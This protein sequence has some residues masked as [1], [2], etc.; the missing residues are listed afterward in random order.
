MK[1]Y[2]VLALLL[3]TSRNVAVVTTS[4]AVDDAITDAD[5]AIVN[6][7]VGPASLRGGMK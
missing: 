1:F 6:A 5:Q 2:N 4:D 7:I 3:A